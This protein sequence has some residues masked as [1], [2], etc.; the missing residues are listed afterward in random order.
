VTSI[1]VILPTYGG[2]NPEELDVAI[3]SILSQS[4]PPNEFLIIQDGG[5]PESNL[6]VISKYNRESDIVNVIKFDENRGRAI[7]RK[8]GVE[9][10]DSTFV[11]MMDADDIS[12]PNRFKLQQRY[13]DSNPDV[14]VLGSYLAEF[15]SDPDKP[16]AV[17]KVPEDHKD[18][19]SMARLRSPIN[20]S[21]VVARR[22][23][24][25]NVGNYRDV[26][27]MAD[28]DLW[29]RLIEDGARFSNLP[30]VLVKARAGRGMHERRGGL[31][32]AREEVRQQYDFAKFGFISP[33]RA[34]INV[35]VRTPLRMVPDVVRGKIYNRYLRD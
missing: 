4:L 13:L 11:A 17:R 7:A 10:A 3:Q 32:Y 27:R 8:T 1:S 16:H 30:T 29:G 18:I 21:T 19:V 34:A 5:V 9:K 31:E 28:Y 2:D 22:D 6:R 20:Q 23:S 14:D 35:L 25:L 24:I 26:S 15:D 33:Y 12:L